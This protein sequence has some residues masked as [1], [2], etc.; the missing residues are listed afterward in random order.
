MNATDSNTLK[1]KAL[2]SLFTRGQ[3]PRLRTVAEHQISVAELCLAWSF[4]VSDLKL[5]LGAEPDEEHQHRFDVLCE[6]ANKK[7]HIPTEI[8]KQ[9]MAY[10]DRQYNKRVAASQ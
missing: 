9:Q 4:Y 1:R 8:A 6:E 3:I 7:C 2:H 5:T 10:L